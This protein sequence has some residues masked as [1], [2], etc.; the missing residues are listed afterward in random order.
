MVP[1]PKLEPSLS[2]KKKLSQKRSR[3]AT[4][5]FRARAREK[6]ITRRTRNAR[7]KERSS[8]VPKGHGF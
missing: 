7:F 8:A 6:H 5:V 3:K 2:S 4:K 1:P